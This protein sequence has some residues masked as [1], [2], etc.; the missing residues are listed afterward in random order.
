MRVHLFLPDCFRLIGGTWFFCAANEAAHV[1]EQDLLAYL[2]E[3]RIPL[4]FFRHALLIGLLREWL[5]R[6]DDC[7]ARG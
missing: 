2:P 4:V 7:L 5:S 3:E 1:E 6:G